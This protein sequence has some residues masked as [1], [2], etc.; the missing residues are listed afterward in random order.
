VQENNSKR[1]EQEAN[2]LS[3]KPVGDSRMNHL[4]EDRE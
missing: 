1:L 3:I 2:E 4:E